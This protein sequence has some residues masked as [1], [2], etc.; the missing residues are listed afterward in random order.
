MQPSWAENHFCVFTHD[1]DF[2]AILAAS[3]AAEPS[4][5][6]IRGNDRLA[7]IPS[8]TG[9]GTFGQARKTQTA[10]QGPTRRTGR[11]L[12]NRPA[13]CLRAPGAGQRKP[14]FPRHR[15]GRN[16]DKQ[17]GIAGTGL[18]ERCGW[19]RGPQ[20]PARTTHLKRFAAK[21]RIGRLVP[22]VGV[23]GRWNLWWLAA[24]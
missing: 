24:G 22:G 10:G 15:L 16:A 5:I 17:G 2:S 7:A 9:P 21:A 6:R 13:E 12:A 20:D 19:R 14:M 18:D 1:L 3:N 4:V 23:S 11:H 8:P